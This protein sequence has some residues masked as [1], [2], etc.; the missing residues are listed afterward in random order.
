MVRK[1]MNGE[2][3]GFA[4]D[5]MKVTKYISYFRS[6]IFINTKKIII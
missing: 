3:V 1:K 6:Y 5:V 4:Y 2:A